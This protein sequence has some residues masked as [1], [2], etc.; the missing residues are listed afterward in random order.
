MTHQG[1]VFLMRDR[2]LCEPAVVRMQQACCFLQLSASR[3]ARATLG[4]LAEVCATVLAPQA[5]ACFHCWDR[6]AA[7][8]GVLIRAVQ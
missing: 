6:L 4:A 8:M 7:D 2:P 5:L 3:F 1:I